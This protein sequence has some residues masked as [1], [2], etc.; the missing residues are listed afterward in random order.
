[1]IRQFNNLWPSLDRNKEV[2]GQTFQMVSACQ[3]LDLILKQLGE[4]LSTPLPVSPHNLITVSLIVPLFLSTYPKL[5][6]L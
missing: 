6:G 3:G 1:M 2:V 5:C 4:I